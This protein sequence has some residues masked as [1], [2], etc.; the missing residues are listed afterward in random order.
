MIVRQ[1]CFIFIAPDVSSLNIS[2]KIENTTLTISVKVKNNFNDFKF[3]YI[4]AA[5]SDWILHTLLY[6]VTTS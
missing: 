2:S 3:E 1:E 5:T 4:I 6:I